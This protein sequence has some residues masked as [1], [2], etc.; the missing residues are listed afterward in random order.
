MENT[1]TNGHDKQRVHWTQTPEGRRRVAK[2]TKQRWKRS[3]YKKSVARTKLKM[4]RGPYTT[5]RQKRDIA[6][7]LLVD[8]LSESA[9]RSLLKRILSNR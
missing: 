9:A 2:I 7:D 5:K 4:K 3:T 8:Q 6:I 1:Q